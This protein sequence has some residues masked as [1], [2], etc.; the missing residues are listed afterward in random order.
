[1][2]FWLWI[3]IVLLTAVIIFLCIKIYLL[4]KSADEIRD[5][6]NERLGEDTNALIDIFC[7]DRHMMRLA[8]DINKELKTLRSRKLKF[9]QGDNQIKE[10]ITNISHDL[11][12]PLTAICGYLD[13]LEREE[14][15]PQ[16]ERYLKIISE[17]TEILKQLT[18]ELFRYSVTVST[19]ENTEAEKVE[20]NSI[21]EES[22]AAHYAEIVSASIT[23]DISITETKIYC[24][25]NKNALMRIFQ[26]IIGNAVKYSDG[27]LNILLSDKGEII[28][29]NHSQALDE[30]QTGKLFDRFYTVEAAEKSTGLGLSI[31]KILTQQ[32]GGKITADYQENMLRIHI[33]FPVIDK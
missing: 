25:L 31:A 11:R 28:F 6:F 32:M 27:D 1:M 3:V 13:L 5:A 19:I 12:T 2:E 23:P 14:K 21:L 33:S 29:S 18:A 17:R 10:A 20:L 7:R 9:Q 16:A 15:S 30:I 24:R 26:N 4:Q 8:C 22:I